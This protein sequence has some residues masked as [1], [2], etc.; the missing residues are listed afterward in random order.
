MD[1]IW[2]F[3]IV[4]VV[5]VVGSEAWSDYLAAKYPQRDNPGED[6]TCL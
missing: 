2:I 5:C 3:L 4:L 6:D 1:G